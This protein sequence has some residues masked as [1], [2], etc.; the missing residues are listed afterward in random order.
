[1]ISIAYD[2]HKDLRD[3]IREKHWSEDYWP[4]QIEANL[5]ARMIERLIC[6]MNNCTSTAEVVKLAAKVEDL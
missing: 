6:R 4:D 2:E 3:R 5:A 1:M